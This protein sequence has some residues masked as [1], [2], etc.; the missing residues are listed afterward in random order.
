MRG[1]PQQRLAAWFHR[2]G[3][4]DLLIAMPYGWLLLFFQLPFLI[5]FAMSFATRT[6]SAP[7]FGY[8]GDNPLVNLAGYARLFS[9]DLYIRAFGTSVLNAAVA[10]IFCLA[11]GYPMALGL[12]G[13][14]KAGATSC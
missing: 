2:R 14:Q 10:T 5:V 12:T 1:S 3:W 9:D 4:S 7:P 8:G 6:A 11:L 13:W